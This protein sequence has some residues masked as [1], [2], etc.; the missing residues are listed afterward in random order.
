VPWSCT[1]T[2]FEHTTTSRLH[3]YV[4]VSLDRDLSAFLSSDST[5]LILTLSS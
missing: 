1:Q 2:Y 4:V 3:D 5:V